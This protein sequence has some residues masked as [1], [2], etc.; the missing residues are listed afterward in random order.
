MKNSWLKLLYK[1][2]DQDLNEQE[3]AALN[4]LLSESAEL[5]KEQQKITGLRS[6]L[7]FLQVDSFEPGFVNRL[8]AELTV[9]EKI[10]VAA[11]G[12]KTALADVFRPVAVA[13]TLTIVALV[14]IGLNTSDQPSF[15]S[16]FGIPQ[17]TLENI[18]YATE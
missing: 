7:N 4:R 3:E 1:S 13:A 2:F 16:L 9:G 8:M 18:V 15:E 11:N 5:R 12:W 6:D 14:V 17:Y 10:M